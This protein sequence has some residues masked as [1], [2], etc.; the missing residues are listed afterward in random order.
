[1]CLFMI[2]VY[3]YL[4]YKGTSWINNS[5]RWWFFLWVGLYQVMV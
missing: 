2:Q 1:V 4:N 3:F 5:W